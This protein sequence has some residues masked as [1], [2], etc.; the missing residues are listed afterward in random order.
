MI[1][2]SANILGTASALEHGSYLEIHRSVGY[3]NHMQDIKPASSRMG[4]MIK[5]LGFYGFLFFLIKGLLW[6]VVPTVI[7]YFAVN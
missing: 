7:A 5:R 3:F 1:F 4:G 6:L 2:S